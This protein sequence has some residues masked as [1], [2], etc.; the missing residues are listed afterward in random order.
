M[1]LTH[2]TFPKISTVGLSADNDALPVPAND[3]G[4]DRAA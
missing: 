4:E 2:H 1:T 3:N